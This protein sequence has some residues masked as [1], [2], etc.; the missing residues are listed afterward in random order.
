MQNLKQEKPHLTRE[1]IAALDNF[2]HFFFNRRKILGRKRLVPEEI[3]IEPVFNRRPD[4][5]L[6]TGI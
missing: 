1:R 6:R 3:V 4:C 5:Y 2:V